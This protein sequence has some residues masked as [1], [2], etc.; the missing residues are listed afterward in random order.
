MSVH[1]TSIVHPS[2]R[3]AEDVVVGPWSQIGED[4]TIGEGL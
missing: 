4:V 2:A 3:L 1:P